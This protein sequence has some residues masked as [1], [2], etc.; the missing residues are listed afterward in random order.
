MAGAAAW[1]GRARCFRRLSAGNTP[2]IL[3]GV[4]RVPDYA[5]LL[6]RF[7]G[8]VGD[9]LGVDVNKAYKRFI[10]TIILASPNRVAPYHTDDSH[11]LLMQV[12][13]SKQ[14]YVFDGSDPAILTPSER[15]AFWRGDTSAALLTDAK[16]DAAIRI[17]LEPSS[18]VHVP[19]TCP[20][21]ARNDGDISV[22]VSI[23]FQLARDDQPDVC[24]FNN[25]LRSMG[26]HPSDPGSNRFVDASKTAAFRTLSSWK[27][28]T[29]A[30]GR[31]LGLK[32]S[33][34]FASAAVA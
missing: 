18:G 29:R 2:I 5:D 3:K 14:F 22:A 24:A 31:N 17:P 23:N 7:L 10:C 30:T 28:W 8:E 4:V 21:W 26:M 1:V 32:Q 27:H 25:L 19:M 12:H 15:D 20:H 6:H 13:G 11:N 9:R 34:A 33:P 16:Q